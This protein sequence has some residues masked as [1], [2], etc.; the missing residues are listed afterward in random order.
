MV[1]SSKC[2]ET[3]SLAFIINVVDR[4]MRVRKWVM[5]QRHR[6]CDLERA[7]PSEEVKP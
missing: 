6:S 2:I 7:Q 1:L 5:S 3:P 4:L